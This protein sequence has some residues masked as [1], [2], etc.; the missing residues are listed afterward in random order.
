MKRIFLRLFSAFGIASLRSLLRSSI[1]FALMLAVS[2]CS[3]PP[4]SFGAQR[5]NVLFIIVDDMTTTMSCQ[6]W[7]GAKTPHL[8]ALAARGVRFEKAYCQFAVCNPARASFLTGCYPEKTKVLDLVTDF[9][10]ALPDIVTLPQHFKNHGYTAGRIGKVFHVPD[11]KTK[12]DL[13]LGAPLHKDNDILNEA[14]KSDPSDPPRGKGKGVSYNRLYAASTRPDADFTDHQI[15]QDT[16]AAIGEF[17]GKP[18]FLATGF[19]RP[20]TP[21]VAPQ[22]AFDAI[23]RSQIKL[24][25]F[26][27]DA[28]EDTSKLPKHALRPN[29]NVFRYAPPTREQALDAMHAY[30]A[31]VHFVDHKIGRVL[32]E[33]DRLGLTDK[34]IIAL[35]GDHG[36]QLG[37]HGLWA[38]QTLFE[39][40]NHVP[41]LFAAPGVKPGTRSGLAEQVDIY[42]TLCD[43]AGLPLP[44]HLQGRSLKSML[45]DPEAKGREVAVS[46][47]IATHTK[48]LGHNVRTDAHRYIAWEG[49]EE[50]LYDLRTDPDELHNLAARPMQAE[51]MNRMRNRLAAHLK[52][53]TAP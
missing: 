32:A 4:S 7:P 44:A 20:H 51:R 17:K 39:G 53:V 2:L 5:P 49:G 43:L 15:A 1:G 22:W 34:T 52:T 14:K 23:D 27:T 42:P 38:K 10:V 25:P 21:F 11:H 40:A 24:P 6:A 3:A 12:L 30:L 50:Q 47:M 35:T 13:E 46:T 29:N 45:D 48:A 9:R 16:I 36:Y 41:L 8:D 28:G 26:Y 31:A 33:L 18:F 37:E 19:I